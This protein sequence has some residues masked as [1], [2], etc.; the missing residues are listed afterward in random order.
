MIPITKLVETAWLIR[1]PQPTQITYDQLLEIIGQDFIK[2]LIKR[3][4][5]IKPKQARRSIQIQMQFIIN[6]IPVIGNLVRKYNI[7]TPMYMRMNR[8]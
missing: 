2:P 8:G 6:I 7:K 5:G 1:Y 3:K 4:K